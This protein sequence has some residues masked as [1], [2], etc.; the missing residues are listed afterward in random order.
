M[1]LSEDAKGIINEIRSQANTTRHKSENY[2][3]KAIRADLS[4][5]QGV[6]EAMQSSFSG[7]DARAGEQAEQARRAAELAQLSEDERNKI[8]K[9]EA[10]RTKRENDLKNKELAIRERE[11]KKRDRSD[12]K[13]FGKDGIFGRLFSGTFSIFKEAM[14][15][16]ISGAILYELSAGF[17]ERFGVKLPTLAEVT[18]KLANLASS[19]DWE[20]LQKN[21]TALSAAEIAA[22]PGTIAAG[23]A[24]KQALTTA[25][26]IAQAVT[27]SKLIDMLGN[28]TP[29]EVDQGGR[30]GGR[31]S[32]ARIGIAGLVFGAV[33]ALTEPVG[34]LIRSKLN[35]TKDELSRE[36]ID[37][38]DVGGRV[39]QGATVGFFIG[40]LKGALI[41][42]LS[43][44]VFG[45][46]E[47]LV[48]II[49]ED[50]LD[51]GVI[52]NV[53]EDAI[54][55][56][57]KAQQKLDDALKER[58]RVLE[59]YGEENADTML[60]TL[61]L[62]DESIEQL[63]TDLNTAYEDLDNIRVRTRT[64]LDDEIAA[65]EQRM[66]NAK[67]R[68]TR[69]EF[70]GKQRY[71]VQ[72]GQVDPYTGEMVTESNV[73]DGNRETEFLNTFEKDSKKMRRMLI[74]L[75]NIRSRLIDQRDESTRYLLRR[76]NE[77]DEYFLEKSEEHSQVLN[78]KLSSI[79]TGM[80]TGGMVVMNNDNRQISYV[81]G[82]RK[83]V[84]ESNNTFLDGF[85]G[86]SGTPGGI[87][88]PG[89]VHTQT[90]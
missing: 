30:R 89:A 16:G 87:F 78:D 49:E 66:E 60:K 26:D 67:V 72:I 70:F 20:S 46:G 13:L 14:F 75:D 27:L 23:I 51:K 76:S 56:S 58:A 50:V 8:L 38:V 7:L 3:L 35:M 25:G 18:T 21:L 86:G 64:E 6:F 1:A 84:S 39:I 90:A 2:S 45:L 24:A 36:R 44:A 53:A 33:Y 77:M 55:K 5:F 81:D 11:L 88:G 17:L 42:A 79:G 61:G 9:D 80:G 37:F 73:G 28:P 71:R 54:D 63:A 40:G 31:L 65:I 69:G 59:E 10:D 74:G 12:F 15:I 68:P 19:T 57:K 52:T 43:G 62:D 34:N 29:D 32:L 83:E 48:D 4:K 41:G 22:I 82:S 85:G 47:L